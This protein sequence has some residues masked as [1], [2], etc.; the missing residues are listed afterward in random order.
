MVRIQP[1]FLFLGMISGVYLKTVLR[2]RQV[3][4]ISYVLDS[5]LAGSFVSYNDQL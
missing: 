5:I 1:R 2:L 3:I 4:E